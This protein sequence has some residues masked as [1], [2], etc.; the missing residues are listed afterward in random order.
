MQKIVALLGYDVGF[1][2]Q[3]DSLFAQGCSDFSAKYPEVGPELVLAITESRKT[4]QPKLVRFRNDYL[5]HKTISREDVA[6]FYSLSVAEIFFESVWVT[7]E[8]VLVV[9]FVAKFPPLLTL[10]EIP[11]DRRDPACPKRFK[12]ALTLRHPARP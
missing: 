10:E 2:F 9:M 3:K 1:L 11:K 12:F 8:T 6:D 7:I 4:W 5:E